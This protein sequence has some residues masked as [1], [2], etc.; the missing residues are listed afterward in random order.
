[1]LIRK[2]TPGQKALATAKY[3][4]NRVRGRPMLM[5]IEMTKHCNAG[6]DFC[7]DWRTQHSPKLGDVVEMVRRLN[8]MVLA[9]TGGEPLLE[10]RLPD[11]VRDIKASQ[12]FVYVYVVTNGSLLTE[13]RALEL[14]GAGLD[15]LSISL[16]YLDERQDRERKIDGLWNHLRDLIPR[17]AA[18]GHTVLTN[19]VIMR[20][21]LEMIVPIARQTHAWGARV[22][23]SCYTHFKNGNRGHYFQPEEL[24]AVRRVVAQLIEH[25]R[26]VGNIT[27]SR[28]YL[29][30][31]VPYFT[32]LDGIRGCKAG[33]RFVQL[34]PDGQVRQCA[35]F[36]PFVHY[37]EYRGMEPT[38]CTRC[39]YACRG[40]SEASLTLGRVAELMHR[41]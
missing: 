30:R 32:N 39:W 1:M 9:L 6:C 20:D 25:R 10:K 28:F 21:N 15:Q 18:R 33:N 17:I 35:D 13:E 38:P 24:D 5:S 26:T 3:I 7:D 34:T 16:N 4:H 12:S 11:I 37:S 31:I 22:S 40:E 41:T 2:L 8:P 29:E 27:N 19:T 14:Y 23:Y 36:A